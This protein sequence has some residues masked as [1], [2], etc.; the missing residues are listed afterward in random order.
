MLGGAGR[1]PDQTSIWGNPPGVGA[2]TTPGWEGALASWGCCQEPPYTE[3]LNTTATDSLRPGAQSPKPKAGCPRLG[4]PSRFFQL[5]GPQALPAGGSALRS[6]PSPRLLGPVSVSPLLQGP[7]R[8]GW[9]PLSD[10]PTARSSTHRVGETC[11]RSPSWATTGGGGAALPAHHQERG[12]DRE[13]GFE[14]GKRVPAAPR[15]P[16]QAEAAR[17]RAHGGRRQTVPGNGAEGGRR[18]RGGCGP[19]SGECGGHAGRHLAGLRLGDPVTQPIRP[20]EHPRG[21]CQRCWPQRTPTRTPNTETTPPPRRGALARASATAPRAGTQAA[22]F[23][24]S[25]RRAAAAAETRAERRR[26]GA[27]WGQGRGGATGRGPL[28]TDFQS[29]KEGGGAHRCLVYS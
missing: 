12:R 13:E 6:R 8:W 9:G 29:G 20:K 3:G 21:N 10:D 15:T 14:E 7:S 18:P 23:S 4:K 25:K 27:P 16:G 1:E 22:N 19:G 2:S 5:L 24:G 26:A 17:G 28:C 11:F